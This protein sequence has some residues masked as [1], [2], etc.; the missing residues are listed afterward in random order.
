MLEIFQNF[1]HMAGRF[2]PLVVI[3]S[4]AVFLLLG[5]SIWLAGLAIR[6]GVFA[7]AG[8]L[9]GSV[10]GLYIVGRNLFSAS[11]TGALAMLSAL[12]LEKLLII[13][14]AAALAAAISFAIV[15]ELYFEPEQAAEVQ[16]VRTDIPQLEQTTVAEFDDIVYELKKFGLDAF[17]KI[18]LA[19]TKIPMHVLSMV[20]VPAMIFFVC[21]VAFWRFTSALFFSVIGTMVIFLGAF[22]TFIYKGL[23]P[24]AYVRG[25]PIIFA[26]VFVVMAVFGMT[27]QLLI[28]KKSKKQKITKIKPGKKKPDKNDEPEKIVEHDWRSA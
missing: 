28:C 22:L 6:K 8:L 12:I 25:K 10:V 11:L 27:V 19:G 2:D 21:G 1:E 7:I 9:A 4:G 13:L 14:L 5:L 26:A 20:V 15:A 24:V 18:Q 16:Q 3:V 17:E 23:E